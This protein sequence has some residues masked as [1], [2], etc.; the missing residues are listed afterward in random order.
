M[1]QADLDKQREVV[2]AKIEKAFPKERQTKGKAKL[3]RGGYPYES[4][5]LK[6]ALEGKSWQEVVNHA[7]IVYYLSE[8]DFMAALSERAYDYYFPAFLI[9]SLNE[10]KAWVY[11]SFVLDYIERLG[12][13]STVLRLEALA[14][15]LGSKFNLN[16]GDGRG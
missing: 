7:Q 5:I 11:Y 9:T 10:P 16:T 4:R 12:E 6:E 8:V 3:T 1:D 13:R 15:W 14:A 2:T